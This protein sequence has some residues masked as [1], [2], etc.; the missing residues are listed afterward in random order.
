[1]P[2]CRISWEL[3]IVK[4]RP[5]AFHRGRT[6][7]RPAGGLGCH[8]TP[9]TGV[10]TPR[11][12]GCQWAVRRDRWTSVRCHVVMAAQ[13][14]AG[15]LERSGVCCR[16]VLERGRA[17]SAKVRHHTLC[18]APIAV[19]PHMAMYGGPQA[20]D[21]IA[22]VAAS[23]NTTELLR[24]RLVVASTSNHRPFLS[25]FCTRTPTRTPAF[26]N[27]REARKIRLPE[28]LWFRPSHQTSPYGH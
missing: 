4:Y 25:L 13:T 11:W 20:S 12:R 10:R 18:Y 24:P 3:A 17:N 15:V 19:W 14:Y 6:R 9:R 16:S 7:A 2:R 22:L 5:V 1:M 8:R 27:S 21:S 28:G 26:C 23:T